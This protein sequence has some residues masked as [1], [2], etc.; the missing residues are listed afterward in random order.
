VPFDCATGTKTLLYS[1][2]STTCH[3]AD[4]IKHRRTAIASYL[5]EDPA[6][7]TVGM[8]ASAWVTRYTSMDFEFVESRCGAVV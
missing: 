6:S 5:K 8:S 2:F 3:R 4:L 7:S 1:T